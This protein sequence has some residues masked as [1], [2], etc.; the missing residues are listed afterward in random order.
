[1]S[2]DNIHLQKLTIG[3]EMGMQIQKAYDLLGPIQELVTANQ[4]P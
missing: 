4:V 3:S 2:G 1:M